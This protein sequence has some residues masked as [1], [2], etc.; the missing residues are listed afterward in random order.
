MELTKTVAARY[1]KA[2]NRKEKT[3]ILDEYCANTGLN[4]KYSIFKINKQNFSYKKKDGRGRKKEYTK[5][6]I[7]LVI[8]AWEVFDK[9]CGERLQ[10]FLAE[11]LSIM[12]RCQIISPVSEVLRASVL[13]MSCST[14]K[15]IIRAEKVR[16]EG[17]SSFSTTKPGTLIK[18]QIAVRA[19]PWNEASP[20]FNEIDLVAHCGGS[21]LGE[22]IYTLQFVDIATTWTERRAVMGKGLKAV[23]K[24]IEYVHKKLLPFELLGID[25][26]NGTEFI[27]YHLKRYCEEENITFTR[28][29]P[30]MKKDNAHIEQKNWPLVRKILGYDR[31]DTQEEL[32]IINDLYDNELRLYINFFLPTMKLKEKIRVGSKYKRKYDEAKTPFQRVLDS[33]D[34]PQEKKD[35]LLKLYQNLNPLQLR[36][37]ID[38]KIAKLFSLK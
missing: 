30:Y 8:T 21:L 28:S 34:V 31:F 9:I 29:R 19:G 6:A 10:P 32:D 1:I 5:E 25:S 37:Q 13:K 14:V 36:H 18:N 17:K 24:E 23:R 2:K 27:N 7:S 22:F 26:D 35:A 3:K 38:K 33:P 20:G 16:T 15:R 12:E 11:A 4:R